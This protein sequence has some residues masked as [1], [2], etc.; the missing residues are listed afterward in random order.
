MCATTITETKTDRGRW[1]VTSE[2][3]QNHRLPFF[4]TPYSYMY[5]KSPLKT[6]LF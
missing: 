2:P 4:I 6:F 5:L 1:F 3:Q